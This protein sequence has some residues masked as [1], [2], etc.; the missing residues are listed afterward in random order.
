MSAA[1][2]SPHGFV[3][4]RGR[5]YPVKETDACVTALSQDRDD[6]WERAARLTVLAREMEAKA[7]SLREVVSALTQQTYESLGSRAQYLLALTVEEAEAL[8]ATARDEAQAV[9]D[10]ADAG[11]RRLYEEAC[12]YADELRADTEA[13]V[14]RISLAAQTAADE[15]RIEAR[16]EVKERL[17]EAV[18]AW[19]EMRRRCEGMLAGLEQEQAGRWEAMER[20][21]A[22]HEAE[23]EARHAELATY[24]QAG[25]A[26]A[27][28]TLAE[29]E[30]NTRPGQEDAE[31]R[32]A[33]L[34][35]EARA[36]EERIARETERVL[37]EHDRS[38]E[39]MDAHMAHIRNSLATLTGRAA[40]E[41]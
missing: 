41:G 17:G 25:L 5:G 32:A 6:A 14:Q 30:E 19:K 4:V 36:R 31:A 20:E 1:P 29:A 9:W 23:L 27:E 35:A 34:I 28:R 11:G 8:L 12:A 16:L 10:A 2:V 26:E 40:A 13:R 7:V 22:H 18:A 24:A 33:A 39:E 38:R 15:A 21:L 37:R 3:A